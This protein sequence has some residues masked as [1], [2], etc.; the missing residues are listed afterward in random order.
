MAKKKNVP[1]VLTPKGIAHWPKLV[2]PDEYQG[3]EAYKTG[4][5]LDPENNEKDAEFVASVEAAAQASY[6]DFMAQSAE[7]LETKT[8]AQKAKLKKARED[9]EVHVPIKPEY[10]DEGEETGRVIL[11]TKM[12][13][14]GVNAKTGKAWNRVCPLFDS[15]GK[16]IN[17]KIDSLWGGSTLILEVTLNPFAMTGTSKAGVSA[18]L[19]AVQVI[20]LSS[21]SSGG[22]KFGVEDGGYCAGEEDETTSRFDSDVADDVEDEDF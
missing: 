22:S 16:K 2:E 13:A 15:R 18:R 9:M 10:D 7:E 4:L 20:E 19:E 12:K 8:G 3:E 1:S 11:E 21:G 14:S 5:I 6:D 17:G